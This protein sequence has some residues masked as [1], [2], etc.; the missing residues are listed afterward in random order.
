MVMS[1]ARE[2]DVFVK[3]SVPVQIEYTRISGRKRL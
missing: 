3:L 2:L 1:Y